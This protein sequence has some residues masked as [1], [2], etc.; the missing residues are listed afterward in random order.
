SELSEGGIDVSGSR[1]AGTLV[2]LDAAA[3]LEAFMPDGRAD[4]D[5]FREVIGT[6]VRRA[7]EVG[8]AV[9][10]YGEMV[11]VL[12]ERGD[13]HGAIEL[14]RLWNELQEELEFSLLCAYP[15]QPASGR[16]HL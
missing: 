9:R 16:E 12:W 13:V 8:T 10:A 4:R 15:S 14:E 11:A 6:V 5:A 1:G 7:S 2:M 3:T